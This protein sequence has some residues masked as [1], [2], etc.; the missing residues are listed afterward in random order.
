MGASMTTLLDPFQADN[1]RLARSLAIKESMRLSDDIIG[2][3]NNGDLLDKK[4]PTPGICIEGHYAKGFKFANS[5]WKIDKHEE[6]P[7]DVQQL[8]DVKKERRKLA[9]ALGIPVSSVKLCSLDMKSAADEATAWEP[10][11]LLQRGQ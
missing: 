4:K 10:M 1:K 6:A 11:P 9:N 3:K 5:N 8:S 2:I 7:R